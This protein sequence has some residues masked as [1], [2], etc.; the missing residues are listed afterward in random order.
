MGL[1][2]IE[3]A[4]FTNYLIKSGKTTITIKSYVND[5]AGNKSNSGVP[6]KGVVF[7]V[8][9]FKGVTGISITLLE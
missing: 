5:T 2:T 3:R 9:L 6:G 4:P 7:L 8:H 1:Y